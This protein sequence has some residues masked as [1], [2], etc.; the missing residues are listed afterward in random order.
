MFTAKQLKS[1]I[2][3]LVIEQFL[4][5]LVGTMDIMMVSQVG[6]YATSGVSL[7]DNVTNLL[8]QAF[9]AMA[10]GGSVVAAHYMGRKE[11]GQA[12]DSA[13]QLCVANTVIGLSIMTGCLLGGRALLGLIYGTVEN[14]VMEAAVIYFTI[15]CISY[16]FFA[17][18][19]AGTALCRAEGNSSITMKVA[20]IVNIINVGG[21]ALLILGF[22]MGTAGV[23]IPTLVSR[24]FGAA[25]MMHVLS[26]E[27][28]PIHFEKGV[29]Y[30]FNWTMTKRIM[31]I[32]IPTGIDG[33]IFQVGRVL[34]GSLT[35]TLG[36]VAIAANA[37]CNTFQGILCIPGAAMG[38]SLITIVGQCLG[39][40]E[41][42][43]AVSYTKKVMGMIHLAA[44][45][46]AMCVFLFH[47]FLLR[48]Y[49]LSGPTYDLARK[50]LM[51]Y[52][53][54]GFIVWPPSFSLAN[55]LRAGG[56]APFV[57][58]ISIS[59][60]WIF[61]VG[62]S[63]VAVYVLKWGLQGIWIAMY[64]DWI[65]R[66]VIFIIRFVSRKWIKLLPNKE[67]EA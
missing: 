61:R 11:T 43:Q 62:L 6:E 31:K 35:S 60:M 67:K 53:F 3:P 1:L 39:A 63:Y 21:N 52:A 4:S 55:A 51:L 37:V 20:I 54:M 58:V 57:M 23:A 16:P 42:E 36:T 8:I 18:Y 66:A 19:A 28:H 10:T 59:S 30:R 46:M 27:D 24:A 41:K 13:I 38:L 9:S 50:V 2:I 25:A 17:L 5:V 32:G 26:K 56:D 7:V 48:L 44:F 34:V 64:C 49:N 47:P 45:A 12:S 29:K 33:S 40:G 22:K 15:T 65:F 14:D